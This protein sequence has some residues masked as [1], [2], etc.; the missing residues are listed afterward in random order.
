MANAGV[1]DGGDL[2]LYAEITTGTMTLIGDAKSHKMTT[3]SEVRTRRTKSTGD[4]PGRKVTG[5]DAQVTTDCL[6][7]YDG[8]GYYDLLDLW[9][10]KKDVK[11]K[12]AGHNEATLGTKEAAGD[13]YVELTCVI[14]SLD[15]NADNDDDVSFTATFSVNG[16]ATAPFAIKT[17]TTGT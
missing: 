15:I 11:L 17:V 2:M 10:Q 5:L 9:N 8:V 7:T 3:S 4:F 16:D 6:V 1:I 14:D 13:K 12:L